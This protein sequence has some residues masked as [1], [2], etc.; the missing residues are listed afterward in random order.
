MRHRFLLPILLSVLLTPLLARAIT[1]D[2]FTSGSDQTVVASG[3]G[4]SASAGFSATGFAVGGRRVLGASATTGVITAQVNSAQGYYSHSQNADSRG[5]TSILWDGGLDPGVNPAGLGSINLAEDGGAHFL[6]RVVRFD[7]AG[8]Q[9]IN[10]KITVYDT[11]GSG[12]SEGVFVLDRAIN[13]PNPPTDVPVL[14]FASLVAVSG[15]GARITHVGALRLELRGDA[16][17]FDLTIDSFG[18]DGPCPLI[19]NSQGRVLDDCGVCGGNN[20]TCLDCLGVPNGPAVPG[21]ACPSGQPG[22]CAPGTY[23]SAC[24][25]QPNNSPTAE[26]CD[27]LDND[28]D[29]LV[30]EDIGLCEDCAGTVGGTAVLDRCGVCNGDGDSCLGCTDRDLTDLL[31]ALD[32]GAKRQE[33]LIKRILSGVEKHAPKKQRKLI[34]QLRIEMHELQIRNWILSWTV[35]V[36]STTC[37]NTQFCVT[38]SNLSIIDEYR[39]NSERLRQGAFEALTYA[40]QYRDVTKRQLARWRRDANELHAQNMALADTVPVAQFSCS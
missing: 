18:T 17:D 37:E 29:G 15:G 7:F 13:P 8:N 25:C 23:D 36:I 35:P 40:T 26:I 5:A 14:P 1:I 4:N 12:I 6:L 32:G 30:D 20:S 27:G 21:T 31:T 9:T 22:V 24:Q 10:G 11:N 16:P 34:T 19:P 38:T 28:C 3:A 33:G 39:V 2:T